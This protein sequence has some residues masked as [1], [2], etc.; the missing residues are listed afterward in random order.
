MQ[1]LNTKFLHEVNE[2]LRDLENCEE[3][4]VREFRQQSYV[5]TLERSMA[6]VMNAEKELCLMVNKENGKPISTD[7]NLSKAEKD[8]Q[9][10]LKQEA[11]LAREAEKNAK[12]QSKIDKLAEKMKK[13]QDNLLQKPKASRKKS[14]TSSEVHVLSSQVPENCEPLTRETKAEKEKEPINECFVKVLEEVEYLVF[15]RK[16]YILRNSK[17]FIESTLVGN[18]EGNIVHFYED[19]IEKT[20][21]DDGDSVMPFVPILFEN[22]VFQGNPSTSTTYLIDKNCNIKNENDEMI[23]TYNPIE[24]KIIL[25]E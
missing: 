16:E 4:T 2:F 11:K 18:Y 7:A 15:Q 5:S 12:N 24:N 10:K 8:I 19:E 25:D 6:K 1:S 22:V 17:L 13:I 3:M 9:K 20:I 21:D 14:V 23:G